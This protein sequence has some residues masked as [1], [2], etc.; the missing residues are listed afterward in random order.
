MGRV[1]GVVFDVAVFLIL[2][3]DHLD[4][5]T[6]EEDY[7]RAKAS[8]FT[9]ERARRGIVCVDDE[10]GRE[11]AG[12]ASVPVTTMTSLEDVDADWRVVV[13]DEEPARFTLSDGSTTLRL[14]SALPGDFNRVNTALAAL[15]LLTAGHDAGRVEEAL[16]ADPHVPGRME[17]VPAPAGAPEDLPLVVVD[18][19]HT[20]DAVAAALR[21]LRP[22]TTGALDV[23]LGAGGDRDRGKRDAM[24]RAAAQFADVVIVT[25][26]N[27]RSE[28][29]ADI[30]SAVLEGAGAAGTR[31]E[32]HDVP[33]RAEAIRQAVRAARDAGPG[34]VVAVVGK[35]H[36]TGQEVAGTVHPFDDRDE[37]RAALVALA[38]LTDGSSRA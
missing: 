17:T 33:G 27:P 13:A 3:R 14:R 19:A 36:E 30:R 32:L 34:G 10:W 28:D 31:A 22:T 8:L 21:A 37:A 5:H 24:G 11:L 6:D 2:G 1:D 7:F 26:D 16:A 15:A 12:L 9:P 29:P 4:F 35:G 23:V 18:Y 20:P 25:D 38:E